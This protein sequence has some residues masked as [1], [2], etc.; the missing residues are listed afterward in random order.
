[1]SHLDYLCTESIITINIILIIL[2][3]LIILIILIIIIII[4]TAG[5]EP[6]CVPT[7]RPVQPRLDR[8]VLPQDRGG[9][10]SLQEAH[11]PYLYLYLYLC[12]SDQNTK[13]DIFHIIEGREQLGLD[14][15]HPNPQRWP[16]Y[17]KCF[18]CLIE[19]DNHI[20]LKIIIFPLDNDDIHSNHN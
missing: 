4:T 13:I 11:G 14:E 9:Q 15:H 1:M 12:F 5:D 18:R 19:D 10:D 2:I 8:A 6:T 20:V 16:R 17:D 3:F 7:P